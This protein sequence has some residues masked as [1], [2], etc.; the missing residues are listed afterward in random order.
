MGDALSPSGIQK[1]LWG[2]GIVVLEICVHLRPNLQAKKRISPR[3]GDSS[4]GP[5]AQKSREIIR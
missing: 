1:S 3:W 4:Q 5:L 2:K